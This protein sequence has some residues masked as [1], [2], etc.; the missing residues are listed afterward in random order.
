MV[1]IL[2]DGPWSFNNQ[3]LLLRWWQRGMT[4]ENIKP[5]HASLWIQIWG[6]PFDMVSFQAEKEV[7]GHLG[8][9][10]EVE[11]KQ[12]HDNSNSFMHAKV[13]LLIGKPLQRGSFITGSDGVRTWVSFMYE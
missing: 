2:Q 9:V 4:V 8:I 7:G 13:A 12:R 3:L 6:A 11:W 1:R 5:E 10:E